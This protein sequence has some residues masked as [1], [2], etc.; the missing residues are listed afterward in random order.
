MPTPNYSLQ[1]GKQTL[2]NFMNCYNNCPL[3]NT[4]PSPHI[5][6]DMPTC[7]DDQTGDGEEVKRG[8]TKRFS[9]GTEGSTTE[10]RTPRQQVRFDTHPAMRHSLTSRMS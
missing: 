7:C 9:F 5:S 3:K 2:S 10:L 6:Y 1:S 4:L 8:T